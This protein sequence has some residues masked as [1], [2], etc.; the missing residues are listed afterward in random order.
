M[1]VGRFFELSL[2]AQFFREAGRLSHGRARSYVHIGKRGNW[3]PVVRG[4]Q[5]I[6]GN[7]GQTVASFAYPDWRVGVALAEGL[8]DERSPRTELYEKVLSS[9][10]GTVTTR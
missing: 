7:S 10:V 3:R 9:L 8:R 1:R 4:E 6:L 5:P 2:V